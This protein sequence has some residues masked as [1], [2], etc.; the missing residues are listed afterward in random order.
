MKS[1]TYAEHDWS[2]DFGS[3]YTRAIVSSMLAKKNA[4]NVSIFGQVHPSVRGEARLGM[5]P[6]L[7]THTHKTPKVNGGPG[8]RVRLVDW[9]GT[10]GMKAPMDTGA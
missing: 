10:S 6:P 8:C 5:H 9:Y 1:H 2:S 4:I 7:H 3:E